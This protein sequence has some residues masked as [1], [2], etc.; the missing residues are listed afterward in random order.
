MKNGFN[1][2]HTVAKPKKDHP[3][4]WCDER[5]KV[6]ESHSKYVGH[7]NGDFQ[8]WRVHEDCFEP[9]HE[10]TERSMNREICDCGHK[11]G[12]KCD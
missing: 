7:H 10:A 11:R 2:F 5:I 1:E 4:A 8:N 9:M 12:A 6:G 3:C